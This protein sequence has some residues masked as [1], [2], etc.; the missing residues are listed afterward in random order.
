[1]PFASL[2]KGFLTGKVDEAQTFADDDFRS[3]Q[4]RFSEE[5]RRANRVFVDVIEGV[6]RQKQATAGQIAPAWLLAKKPWIVPIP[7]TTKLHRL[8][9]DIG[10]TKV[11][12]TT[13]DVD[14]I[15]ASLAGVEAH[16]DRYSPENAA[17][18]G[19]WVRITSRQLLA[20]N[21]GERSARRCRYSRHNRKL[22]SAWSTGK[23]DPKRKWGK[24]DGSLAAV[25]DE[26]GSVS[27]CLPSPVI[28]CRASS[29]LPI[30]RLGLS[31]RY[32][33]QQQ[34]ACEGGP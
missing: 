26:P 10:S 29:L 8:E 19:R 1:V 7:G 33:R 24:Y 25:F 34:W 9:E 27:S 15:E 23:D 31:K 2:G 17:M 20:L 11:E 22:P 18:V 14:Q 13:A 12:L 5:N 21:P 4:P 32:P 30:Q 28:A 6:A 3:R 16:G